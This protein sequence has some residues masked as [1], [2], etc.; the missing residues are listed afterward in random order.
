MT[1]RVKRIPTPG[2]FRSD[3]N[4]ITPCADTSKHDK[5]GADHSGMRDE[6]RTTAPPFSRQAQASMK[7]GSAAVMLGDALAGAPEEKQG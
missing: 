3:P 6:I 4:D 5:S 1:H 2:G 7:A